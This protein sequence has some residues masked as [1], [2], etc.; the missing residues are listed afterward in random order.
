MSDCSAYFQCSDVTPSTPA[1]HPGF[2][3]FTNCRRSYSVNIKSAYIT[4]FTFFILLLTCDL[5]KSVFNFW[6][7]LY[8][9]HNMC[10]GWHLDL[11]PQMTFEVRVMS[12]K[13]ISRTTEFNSLEEDII[14]NILFW[15]GQL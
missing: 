2:K 11:W 1:A 6:V 7:K 10:N 3:L 8:Y 5:N 15:G 4:S 12:V 13:F 9:S 14:I